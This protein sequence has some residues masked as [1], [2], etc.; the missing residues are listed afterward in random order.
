VESGPSHML[1]FIQ[2]IGPYRTHLVRFGV[3]R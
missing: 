1:R 2:L 3:W